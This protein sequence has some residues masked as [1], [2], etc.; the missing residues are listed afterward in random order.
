MA[1]SRG[2]LD[3]AV[4]RAREGLRIKRALPDMVGAL[5]CMDLLSWLLAE[6]G[7]HQRAARLLEACATLSRKVGLELF[8]TPPFQAEHERCRR[9]V[10][11]GLSA[12][13]LERA[14]R[15]GAAMGFEEAVAEALGE[16]VAAP[17]APRRGRGD[18]LTPR[19]W[20]VAE[21][22]AQ[23]L[24]NRE[25]ADR[26]VVAA[27]TVDSHVAH[28]LAKLGFSARAQ[29][30]AWVTMRKRDEERGRDEGNAR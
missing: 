30:A 9:L 17:A 18:P 3:G 24:T 26:L 25:I 12:R 28:I 27:R 11:A 8:D 29:V 2:D 4:A 7:E 15:Q 13:E 6:R 22:V 10:R 19:E 5:L 16:P 23:G 20:E 14:V 1:R 21:L